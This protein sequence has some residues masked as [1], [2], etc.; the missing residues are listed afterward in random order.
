MNIQRMATPSRS[1]RLVPAY[2]SRGT[3][4]ILTN[5]P[6]SQMHRSGRKEINNCISIRT[7]RGVSLLFCFFVFGLC[8]HV[9][10]DDCFVV[11]DKV[12]TNLERKS[13]ER[14]E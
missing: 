2:R 13:T 8:L 6:R 11:Y 9:P 3:R 14:I 1:S 10:M 5:R 4:Q 12:D 7:T